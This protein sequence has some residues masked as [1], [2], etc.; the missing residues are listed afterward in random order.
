MYIAIAY[1]VPD[2]MCSNIS[3]LVYAADDQ[4]QMYKVRQDLTLDER[5]GK[6]YVRARLQRGIRLHDATKL[7]GE[8]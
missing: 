4:T 6:I 3:K 5:S 8:E 7:Q 1:S 2:V